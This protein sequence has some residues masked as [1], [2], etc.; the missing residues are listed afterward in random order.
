M[1][2][3]D[4]NTLVEYPKLEKYDTIVNVPMY[5][6]EG[7]SQRYS[8]SHYRMGVVHSGRNYPDKGIDPI[9]S[10]ILRSCEGFMYLASGHPKAHLVKGRGIWK[11]TLSYI[12]N[13]EFRIMPEELLEQWS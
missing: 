5:L 1:A 12:G 6:D 4:F 10:W 2:K 7:L 9:N 11:C 8:A 13:D 3:Y